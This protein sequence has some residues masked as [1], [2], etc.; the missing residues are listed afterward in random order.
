MV[1]R[2]TIGD[3]MGMHAL[4]CWKILNLSLRN[5]PQRINNDASDLNSGLLG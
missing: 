5:V 3:P 1:L 2:P 4:A